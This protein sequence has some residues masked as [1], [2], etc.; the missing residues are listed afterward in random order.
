MSTFTNASLIHYNKDNNKTA[1]TLQNVQSLF[2]FRPSV[3]LSL[4]PVLVFRSFIFQTDAQC[5]KKA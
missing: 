1:Q 4:S 5:T 2:T 3:E